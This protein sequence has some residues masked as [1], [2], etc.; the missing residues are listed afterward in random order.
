MSFRENLDTAIRNTACSYFNNS[1]RLLDYSTGLL[2]RAPVPLGSI[3]NGSYG[4]V[5]AGQGFFCDRPPFEPVQPPFSGGQCPIDYRIRATA[6]RLVNGQV[7]AEEDIQN[8]SQFFRGPIEAVFLTEGNQDIRVRHDGG[9]VTDLASGDP[10]NVTYENLRDI[11]VS[12]KR[13]TDDCG[14][15]EPPG[16]YPPPP[17]RT[18]PLP[19]P[20]EGGDTIINRPIFNNNGD[21]LIPITIN[22]PNF[23]VNATLNLI[24]NEINYNFGGLPPESECCDKVPVPITPDAPQLPPFEPDPEPPIE[25]IG[26]V[27]TTTNIENMRG[28]TTIFQNGNPDI[29]VPA[30]GYINF[31]IKVGDTFAW[32]TDIAIKNEQQYVE[33]PSSFPAIDVAG[34]PYGGVTWSIDSIKGVVPRITED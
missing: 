23:N 5:N 29:V 33:N 7:A 21:V 12:P 3:N 19:P 26:A 32:T 13:G 24:K 18:N 20:F 27:V 25:I 11:V 2:N 4:L 16:I 17:E 6:T 22:G 30:L 28:L 31:K 10:Q 15:I 14:D 1:R 8:G 34:T 9:R